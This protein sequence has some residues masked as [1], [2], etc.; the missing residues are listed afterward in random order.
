MSVFLA[1]PPQTPP[2]LVLMPQGP[3]I[4]P[5][6]SSKPMIM[7]RWLPSPSVDGLV[8]VSS[9]QQSPLRTVPCLSR[10]S[11]TLLTSTVLMGLTSSKPEIFTMPLR[12]THVFSLLSWEY[13]AG[14]GIGCNLKS[15][16][17]TQN[18]LA[19]LQELRQDPTGKNL[20]ISAAVAPTTFIGSDGNPMTNLSD[21][22]AVLNHINV[23]NYDIN[24]GTRHVS[25][26]STSDNLFRRAN[27]PLPPASAPTLLWMTLVLQFRLV[28][29]P[30]PS[31]LGWLLAS[32]RT[33]SCLEFPPTAIPT[34]FLLP[35]PLTAL[36][37]WL[38]TL[39][40]PRPL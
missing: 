25:H 5:P 31:R 39:P 11:S 40:S 6:S 8:P 34:T 19:F 16:S 20:Y 26:R 32:P 28:L 17:D 15:T 29:R 9:L 24:V 27:G 21:F 10:R 38:T 7:A 14:T 4:S 36:G 2:P 33:R 13:P 23:M 35:T 22:A 3:L 1:S 30:R 37:T 12:A 18:F